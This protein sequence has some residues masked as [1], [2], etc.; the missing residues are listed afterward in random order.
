M[1]R[2]SV[3]AGA[4]ALLT[5]SAT[6]PLRAD[7]ETLQISSRLIPNFRVGSDQTRFGDFEFIGGLELSSPSAALGAMSGI[8]LSAD[9]N[10]FLGV[11]DTGFWYAGRFERGPDGKLIGIADFTVSPILDAEGES[12]EEKWRVDAEGLAVRGEEVLVSFERRSRVDVYPANAP[13]SSRP[14]GSLPLQIPLKE[15]R[16]NRGL[17]AIMVAPE[18]SALAGEVVVVSEKSLNA[19]GDIYAAV[20]TGP[21]KGVF[22]VKRHPPYDVTDGDFLPNGDLLLLERRFSIAEGIG[23][24]IRRIDGSRLVPGNLVDGPV[25]LEADFGEQIDNMEGLDVSTDEAG[26]TFV[27]LVSDDNHSILQRNLVLEFRY[28]GDAE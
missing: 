28:L 5:A 21:S 27:T 18:A 22:F 8:R 1:A 16:N 10:R 23:M 11:M 14:T 15:L 7:D 26:Q 13:G 25:L 12:S 24:R 9:R 17:E 4:L 3:I 20:L 6:F 2:L 19:S